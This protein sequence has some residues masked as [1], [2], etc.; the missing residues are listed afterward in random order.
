MKRLVFDIETNIVDFK[1]G[2]FL[3]DIQTIH[4]IVIYNLDTKK[5]Y[6]Y[7]DT[8]QL[9][10]LG[11]QGI[12]AAVKELETADE[13]IGHNIIQFDIPVLRKLYGFKPT[14]RIHDTLI[15]SRTLYPDRA[16]GHSL[17]EWGDRLG[18]PKG[19][20][21]DFGEFSLELLEYCERDTRLTAAVY[22]RLQ[23]ERREG[24]W[25]KAIDL[26]HKVAEII[27]E[28]ERNGFYFDVPK[29]Q[30]Y[31]QEWE[32]E[33]N[34]IDLAIHS[35]IRMFVLSGPVVNKPF[36][37]NGAP[38]ARTL[39]VCDRYGILVD[40]VG[41]PFS[42][43][44][45]A[46]LDLNS[47]DKQKKLLLE[48]GWKPKYH[49]KTGGPQL[50][51]SILEVGKVGELL[52]RR[53]VLSHRH[54]Q[55][56]GLIKIADKNSRV[57]GGA[58]PCGTNTARMRHQRIVNLPRITSP[59]GKELRSL[60]TVPSGKCLVGYDAKSL[61]LRIL[62]H[63]IDNE[64]YN[65]RV[66]T[67]DK[68]KDAHILSAR[69]A[70]SS[71]RDLGKTINYALIYGAGDKKLGTIIGGDETSGAQLRNELYKSVPGLEGLTNRAKA[72]AQR[73]FIY[74]L[75]G[76]KLYL[77]QRVS[78]L[79]TLIQGGGAIFMKTVA[80]FLD[81]LIKMG[82]IDAIKVVDMHDE[83]QLEA[84]PKDVPKLEWCIHKAFELT[85][86]RLNL[87]CPQEADVKVGQNWA[88]TH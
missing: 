59:L 64:E 72:A 73:G 68:T 38:A 21:T 63:Y 69:A 81:D 34:D 20:H 62:A 45:Y 41:G 61:E 17:R 48:L 84:D 16:G 58:N 51:D 74:G 49:T 52:A 54:N 11:T 15:T 78:P 44:E 40:D 77:R 22:L 25:E 60:F 80:V 3:E 6:Q 46:P 30:Q 66:T 10:I 27:A 47:K 8:D 9:R 42:T 71:D 70:G 65:E 43:F 7:Y 23:A 56:F 83:A 35:D 2:N 82:N 1:S 57:H 75:D 18:Y 50:C 24:D 36:K 13:I 79:N 26:E 29:A 53:N 87:K 12:E 76:R 67:K 4:C 88:E 33:I 19:D 86:E 37:I 28:Q 5:A 32:Q 55:V 31:V 14:G 85:T 39:T